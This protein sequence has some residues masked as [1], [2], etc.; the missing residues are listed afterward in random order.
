VI[1]VDPESSI[2]VEYR[3]EYMIVFIFILKFIML[4][5]IRN[6]K[7]DLLNFLK[8]YFFNKRFYQ[9]MRHRNLHRHHIV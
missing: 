9:V 6:R 2:E 7:C 8:K 1:L 4:I 3:Q 5:R